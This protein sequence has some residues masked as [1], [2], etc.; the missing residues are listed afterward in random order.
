VNIKQFVCCTLIMLSFMVGPMAETTSAGLQVGGVAGFMGKKQ[1]S[2]GG[3]YLSSISRAQSDL[4]TT[5]RIYGVF[6]A[7]PLVRATKIVFSINGRLGISND[8]FL[9]V[10]PGFDTRIQLS[11]WAHVSLGA[12]W[13]YGKPALNGT[14]IFSL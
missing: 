6:A 4:A 12:G 9:V 1:F 10:V 3:F 11:R 7:I 8:Q 5:V 13:R 14:F 2:I